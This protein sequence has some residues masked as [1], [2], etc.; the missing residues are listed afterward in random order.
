MPQK[1]WDL[2]TKSLLTTFQ[3]P[4][5]ITCITWDAAERLFFAASEDGSIH[6]V[7]L[8]RTRIDKTHGRMAEAVGGAGVSDSLSLAENERDA[9][10]RRLVTVGCVIP[11]LRYRTARTIQPYPTFY[12]EKLLRLSVCP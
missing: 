11:S 9:S 1:L 3:F 4:H 7:N 5:A 12:I 6:Q 8:Y 10:N 2:E